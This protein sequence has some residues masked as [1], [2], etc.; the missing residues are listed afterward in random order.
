MSIGKIVNTKPILILSIALFRLFGIQ[1]YCVFNSFVTFFG[2]SHMSYKK[3]ISRY[4]R[5]LRTHKDHLHIR[6]IS[7]LLFSI[8]INAQILII[9]RECA[10]FGCIKPLNVIFVITTTFC[11]G[12]KILLNRKSKLII[13]EYIISALVL[14]FFSNQFEHWFLIILYKVRHLLDL[15]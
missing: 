9:E 6:W 14:I 12:V 11:V 1:F 15:I 10:S 5:V 4:V 3:L 2:F 7:F 13:S 8:K